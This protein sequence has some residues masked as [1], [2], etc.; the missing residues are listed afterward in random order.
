MSELAVRDYRPADEPDWLRC[1]VLAFLSTSYFDDVVTSK[2]TYQADS[3]ELVAV[4]GGVLVGVLDVVIGG[5]VATI[6]TIAVHPDASRSGAGSALLAEAIRRLPATVATVD[7]WTRG[8]EAANRWYLRQ[9]FSE[10]FRYLHV[11]AGD[12]GEI[13]KAVTASRGLT[14]VSGF[15]HARIDEED[16]LRKDFRR[17][18]IC[19]QY[20]RAIAR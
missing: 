13:E 16:R 20:V 2:P 19:R 5:D 9:G 4:R 18:H 1:R 3:I 14:P 7:A 11:F 10:N 17:V 15:F 6:E 8:D 12:G